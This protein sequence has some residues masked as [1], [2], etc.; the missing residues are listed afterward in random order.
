M[1][2]QQQDVFEAVK[3]GAYKFLPER[4]TGNV[5]VY[6][7]YE[8]SIEFTYDPWY[9]FEKRPIIC[10]ERRRQPKWYSDKIISLLST[11]NSLTPTVMSE[12]DQGGYLDRFSYVDWHVGDDKKLRLDDYISC[13]RQDYNGQDV[14]KL[15]GK[16]VAH[17]ENQVP[18]VLYNI[19]DGDE[20]NSGD[21]AD[22]QSLFM[23]G[24]DFTRIKQL[25]PKE[26]E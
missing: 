3:K 16:I 9:E 1:D 8:H 7:T 4:S 23:S 11:L 19:E 20:H 24:Y 5:Y 25:T 12:L 15:E 10:I 17:H 21:Y 14:E 2:Q 13:N 22:L 18:V 26:Q 6:M